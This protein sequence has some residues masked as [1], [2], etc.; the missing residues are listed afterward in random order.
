MGANPLLTESIP[1]LRWLR[2][3]PPYSFAVLVS[4]ADDGLRT[5]PSAGLPKHP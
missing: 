4:T 1:G 5:Q 3:R 2:G